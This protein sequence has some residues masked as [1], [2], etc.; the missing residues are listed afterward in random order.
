MGIKQQK[1]K[2]KKVS[3]FWVE[4]VESAQPVRPFA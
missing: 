1:K 2:T 3:L 4:Q